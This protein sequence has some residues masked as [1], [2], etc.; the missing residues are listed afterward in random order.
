[1]PLLAPQANILE[2]LSKKSIASFEENCIF[3]AMSSHRENVYSKLYL[4]DIR[5]NALSQNTPIPNN[6]NNNEEL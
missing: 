3:P 6:N 1:M 5:V 4:T 2:T